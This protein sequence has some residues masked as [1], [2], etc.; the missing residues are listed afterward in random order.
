MRFS[1]AG[2]Y[3]R[4]RNIKPEFAVPGVNVTGAIPGGSFTER[5]GSS[6]GIAI[7]AGS[8]ALLLQWIIQDQGA[9]ASSS[10]IRN[11]LILG[12]RRNPGIE[13][14]NRLWGYGTMDLYHT[15]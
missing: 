6:V 2:G 9:Q 5:S 8:A 14:P 4:D 13:Y 10:Q 15:F 1:P 11:I 12:T 7:A 3:T